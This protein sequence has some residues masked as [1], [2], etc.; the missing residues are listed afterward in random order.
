VDPRLTTKAG[1]ALPLIGVTTSEIRRKDAVR[2]VPEGEPAQVELALGLEYVRS[3]E[4]AGGIPVVLPPL[5]PEVVGPLLLRLSGVCLSGGPDID[6]TAYGSAPHPKLGPTEP[7]VDRF[8]LEVARLAW[9]LGMP[10]LAICRGAQALNVS[11]G[12]TLVQHLPGM[13]DD[14][15]QHRQAS[16]AGNA[17]HQVA[18]QEGTLLEDL[19]GRATLNVNSFHHQAV[20]RLG[21]GLRV[22]AVATDGVVEAVEAPSRPFVLGVQW[23]AECLSARAEHE[24]LF[25]GLTESA[26]AYARMRSEQAA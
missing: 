16:P 25:Q 15:L 1:A 24:A 19:M 12:G 17:T 3:I 8:E 10:L 7:A 18:V 2:P 14:E 20:E 4:R 9:Q 23:H 22:A 5:V 6:P 21:R 13:T 11:R 26:R